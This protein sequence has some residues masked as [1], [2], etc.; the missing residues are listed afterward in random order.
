MDVG[1]DV[2]LFK[3]MIEFTVDYFK[4]NR[5]GIFQQRATVP[6]EMGLQSLPWANIGSMESHGIDGNIT[7]TKNWNKDWRTPYVATSPTLATRSPTGSSRAF[8]I[9]TSHTLAFL[10]AYSVA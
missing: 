3:D 9:H 10:T 2:H 1:V 8:V 6:D 7:F 4:D 5:S